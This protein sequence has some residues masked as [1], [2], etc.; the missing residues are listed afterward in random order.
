[1]KSLNKS[2]IVLKTGKG[3]VNESKFHT[4]QKIQH[5]YTTHIQHK[6]NTT[7]KIQHKMGVLG[8][9]LEA[10]CRYPR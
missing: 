5:V 2:I 6:I 1:M 7:R 9:G 3:K 8:A 4:T 10:L